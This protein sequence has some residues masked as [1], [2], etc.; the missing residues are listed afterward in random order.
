MEADAQGASV[1]ARRG[2]HQSGA[3]SAEITDPGL[4][5]AWSGREVDRRSSAVSPFVPAPGPPQVRLWSYRGSMLAP[6]TASAAEIRHLS[7][8]V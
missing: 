6:V 5:S 4:P 1:G 3:E 8:T 7:W 2:P